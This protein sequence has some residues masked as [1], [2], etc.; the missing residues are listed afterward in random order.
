M[1][2]VC[3]LNFD[4]FQTTCDE[5]RNQMIGEI[6]KSTESIAWIRQIK[7]YQTRK[8]FR[9]HSNTCT[10]QLFG[11]IWW[12]YMMKTE[13][14]HINS[15]KSQLWSLSTVVTEIGIT[16]ASTKHAITY[17]YYILKWRKI[18]ISIWRL[19]LCMSRVFFSSF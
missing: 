14:K 5:W 19:F 8:S 9:V 7:N 13:K 18:F 16:C 2:I 3:S 15:L 17:L 6:S 12:Q 11:P 1:C 10:T 4:D